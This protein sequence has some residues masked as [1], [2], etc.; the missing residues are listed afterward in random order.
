MKSAMRMAVGASNQSFWGRRCSLHGRVHLGIA[1]PLS[2]PPRMFVGY[3]GA[4]CLT[5][6]SRV[7]LSPPLPFTAAV[8]VAWPLV[9]GSRPQASHEVLGEKLCCA[10]RVHNVT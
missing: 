10:V 7:Y 5:V 8:R 6:F 3:L 4:P 2:S 9:F 1:S